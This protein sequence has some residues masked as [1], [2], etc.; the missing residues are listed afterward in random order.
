MIRVLKATPQQTKPLQRRKPTPWGV[1]RR[2]R[3]G[4]LI[5]P[6]PTGRSFELPSMDRLELQSYSLY[7]DNTPVSLSSPNS[8]KAMRVFGFRSRSAASTEYSFS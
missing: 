5:I 8:L 2:F 7:S 1:V 6:F 3:R 4:S